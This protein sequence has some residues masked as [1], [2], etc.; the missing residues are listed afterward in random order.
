[1]ETEGKAQEQRHTQEGAMGT[2][3]LLPGLVK[4]MVSGEC[5]NQ[6]PPLSQVP[7]YAPVQLPPKDEK[8][9]KDR[10]FILSHIHGYF[11]PEPLILFFIQK[12]IC[13]S[14]KGYFQVRGDQ[15]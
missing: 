5:D 1:M 9:L 2:Q 12:F 11:F 7:V 3:P 15:I 14:V 13:L 8:D 4:S 10:Y 6:P